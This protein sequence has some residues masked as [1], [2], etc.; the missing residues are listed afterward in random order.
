M[1]S[2]ALLTASGVDTDGTWNVIGCSVQ[3]SEAEPHGGWFPESLQKRGLHGVKLIVSDDH[4][5]RRS[6]LPARCVLDPTNPFPFDRGMGLEWVRDVVP[7]SRS[8]REER[9]PRGFKCRRW[10]LNPH[11]IAGNGF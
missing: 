1:R 11:A 4:A 10:D 3:C 8:W 2:C 7:G 6:D 5:S 9:E